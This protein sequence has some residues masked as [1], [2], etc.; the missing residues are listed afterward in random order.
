MKTLDHLEKEMDDND[1]ENTQ[2]K[3]QKA[4]KGNR[5]RQKHE[6]GKK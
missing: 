5:G 4:K 3:M 2:P 1:G 6:E